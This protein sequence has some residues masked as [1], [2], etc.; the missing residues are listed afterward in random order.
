HNWRR[1]CFLLSEDVRNINLR[2]LR[3]T[4]H[5]IKSALSNQTIHNRLFSFS[6]VLVNIGLNPLVTTDNFSIK[7]LGPNARITR[8]WRGLTRIWSEPRDCLS[9]LYGH[10]SDCPRLDLR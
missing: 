6:G 3:N 10:R 1:T 4:V 9:L 5:L 8:T 2:I 7:S